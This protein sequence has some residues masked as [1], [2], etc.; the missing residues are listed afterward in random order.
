M[1]NMSGIEIKCT[2]TQKEGLLKILSEAL[3]LGRVFPRRKVRQ[4]LEEQIKWIDAEEI[5]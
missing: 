2:E 1:G 4:Q 5:K 3:S